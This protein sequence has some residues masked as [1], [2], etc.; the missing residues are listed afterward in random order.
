[1]VRL[2]S[3]GI[4]INEDPH[5]MH[6]L[7]SKILHVKYQGILK[8]LLHQE[9]PTP[10][11]LNVLDDSGYSPFLHYIKRFVDTY[12]GLSGTLNRLIN[13]EGASADFDNEALFDED[14]IEKCTV[15]ERKRAQRRN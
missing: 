13:Y 2:L 10:D 1:M 6:S 11:A 15:G 14:R 3:E 9:I 4:S 8:D 5:L 7:A 12:E